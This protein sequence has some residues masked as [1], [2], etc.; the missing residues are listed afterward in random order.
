TAHA[1][2]T[3]TT[4]MR[5]LSA[6]VVTQSRLA[7]QFQQDSARAHI[8]LLGVHNDFVREHAEFILGS[9]SEI[10]AHAASVAAQARGD[11]GIKEV[12]KGIGEAW[13]PYLLGLA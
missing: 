10:G 11:S 4:A 2:V 13:A 3:L 5:D 1:L 7:V 6:Q 12:V 8:E 9:A